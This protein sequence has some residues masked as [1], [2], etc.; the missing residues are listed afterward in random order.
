SVATV[1]ALL[2]TEPDTE[3]VQLDGNTWHVALGPR[4]LPQGA[5]TSPALTN[6]IC[7]RLD[8]RLTGLAQ[9]LGFVYTRYA[10]DLTFSK[11]VLG[12][13]P[14][15]GRLLGQA[16]HIIEDEGFVVHPDKTRVL[17]N[18]RQ[19][20]VT[21]LVVNDKLG[22]PRKTL[23]RFRA[24]LHHVKHDGPEGKVWNGASGEQLFPAML[25]FAC[26]VHMVDPAKGAVLRAS[27]RALMAR[28]GFTPTQ[29]LRRP[30]TPTRQPIA[31]TPVAEAS[32]ASG[33]S[34]NPVVDET[35]SESPETPETSAG[36]EGEAS[37]AKD[38]KKKWWKL[39]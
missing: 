2:C 13:Q 19:Q 6:I 10:D 36:E 22:V 26:F 39:F 8:R 20:E 4:H 38:S 14:V 30:Q 28:Y 11:P 27:V 3:Q 35:I 33:V 9:E 25:G 7:R 12:E 24:L 1:L 31:T 17:R 5:P 34:N 21:G 18:A 23:R 15:I 37:D 29:P 16:G 32:E